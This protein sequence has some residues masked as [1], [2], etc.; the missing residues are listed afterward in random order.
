MNTNDKLLFA[1]WA[2]PDKPWEILYQ[3]QSSNAWEAQKIFGVGY[4]HLGTV[5]LFIV[6]PDTIEPLWLANED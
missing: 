4:N 2:E 1:K 6:T 5:Y 3:R